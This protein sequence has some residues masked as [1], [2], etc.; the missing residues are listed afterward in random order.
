MVGVVGVVGIGVSG[1][2]V[3]PD[4]VPGVE[5]EGVELLE[6]MTTSVTSSA[7]MSSEE[8][9]RDDELRRWWWCGRVASEEWTYCHARL[10]PI[11]FGGWMTNN[12]EISR[13]RKKKIL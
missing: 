8:E 9:L 13:N 7:V 5:C 6:F 1:Y 12:L 11:I 10:E 2:D 4:G 3:V